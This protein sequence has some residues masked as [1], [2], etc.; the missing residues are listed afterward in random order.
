[1]ELMNKLFSNVNSFIVDLTM[2][3][4]IYLCIT[5]ECSFLNLVHEKLQWEVFTAAAT[6]MILRSALTVS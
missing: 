3:L 4:F 6:L 1:M 5:F 2:Q